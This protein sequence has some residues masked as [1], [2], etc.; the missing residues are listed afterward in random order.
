MAIR[1]DLKLEGSE[2]QVAWAEDLRSRILPD[3]ERIKDTM[4]YGLKHAEGWSEDEINEVIDTVEDRYLNVEDAS[5]WI[6]TFRIISQDSKTGVDAAFVAFVM[7][8]NKQKGKQAEG[9][10]KIERYIYL[11]RGVLERLST[12]KASLQSETS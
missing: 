5:Y 3:Y 1:K 11:A 2:K 4:V 6:D 8:K 9:E 12:G 7:I 10:D